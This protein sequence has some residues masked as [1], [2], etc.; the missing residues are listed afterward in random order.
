MSFTN[1]SCGAALRPYLWLIILF[2]S[3][4]GQKGLAKTHLLTIEIGPF[5]DG[6]VQRHSL[7][8]DSLSD[9]VVTEFATSTVWTE[10]VDRFS[11]VLLWD[12]LLH[13]GV[14]PM[15]WNGEITLQAL[16]GYSVTLGPAH[17]TE[18]AP[19]LAVHQ[20]GRLMPRRARGPV[21]LV[22]PYDDNPAFRNETIYALS[23]WQ[24]EHVS[25]KP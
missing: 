14:E 5:P 7:T 21:W 15:G 12:M 2:L 10:G 24:I 25:I 19:L 6:S 18:N 23:V 20:N 11:G 16:D 8:T 1:R 3:V 22:F 17:V 9:M 4:F 13:L